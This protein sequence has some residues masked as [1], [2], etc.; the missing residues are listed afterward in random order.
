MA[1]LGAGALKTESL[2]L[3]GTIFRLVIKDGK[4][5][6]TEAIVWIK[7]VCAYFKSRRKFDGSRIKLLRL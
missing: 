1:L 7:Y 3:N 6:I 4:E 2:N 5:D